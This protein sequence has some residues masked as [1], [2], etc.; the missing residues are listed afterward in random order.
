VN[1]LVDT[2]VVS[3]LQRSA[4]DKRVVEAIERLSDQEIHFSVITIG[5]IT[6]GI[7]L[8]EPGQQRLRLQRW[9][10]GIE[11][12]YAGQIL[13][14]DR[15]VARLWGEASARFRRIGVTVPVADGLIAATAVHHALPLMTRNVR[16]FQSMDIDV[17]DPWG[18]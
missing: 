2:C 7:A 12:D 1:V 13:P 15:E 3:E 8:L 16:H 11:Q 6:K 10:H 4:P 9:L 17:I 14:V 5:E 18:A